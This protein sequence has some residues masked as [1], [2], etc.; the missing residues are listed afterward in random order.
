MRQK[1]EDTGKENLKTFRYVRFMPSWISIT[2]SIV[3]SATGKEITFKS[4]KSATTV[5]FLQK[6]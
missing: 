6:Y 5:H 4:P 1:I 2:D 3:V